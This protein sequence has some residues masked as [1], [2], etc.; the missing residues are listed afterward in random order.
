MKALRGGEK[1][2]LL[3]TSKLGVPDRRPLTVAQLR[4]LFERVRTAGRENEV[5]DLEPGDLTAMGYSQKDALHIW[6]LLQE[7]ELLEY[8]LQRGSKADCVPLT[9]ANPR[10]P[11]SVRKR[12]GLDAPGCLWAKGELSLLDL[13]MVALVGSRE[14]RSENAAFAREVG[15]QAARQ[16]YA[17]VSGNA[18]GADKTAQQACL[19]E[20]GQVISVVADSLE[21]HRSRERVLYLS[22]DSFD[23]PFTAQRA[24]SRNRVIHTLGQKT[25]VAQTSLHTGGTWDGTV[26]NL[27]HRWSDV[28]CYHDDTQACRELEQQGAVVI[29]LQDLAQMDR[30][31]TPEL[32]FLL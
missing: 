2:F 29:T 1:G 12:L 26:K 28:F 22:E 13:P 18:R 25:F 7:Q 17:L 10:Y 19:A 21:S 6:S 27:Q 5:R 20:G 3:L 11:L 31:H 15:R 16:G 23:L 32:S 8:Y 30:L 4:R 14:L 24:L 9:R